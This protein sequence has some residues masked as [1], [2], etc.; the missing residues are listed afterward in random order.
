M[1]KICLEV[2]HSCP[3]GCDSP[4]MKLPEVSILSLQ[5]SVV[6]FPHI[7]AITNPLDD[8]Y[9]ILERF[10][11]IVCWSYLGIA[12]KISAQVRHVH[13]FQLKWCLWR[14]TLM[15]F[16]T[17][18]WYREWVADVQVEIII[19]S[20]DVDSLT[21]CMCKFQAAVCLSILFCSCYERYALQKK[22]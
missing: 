19:I 20:A 4:K 3:N 6:F 22:H 11:M 12:K 13:Y 9:L 5:S 2:L 16:S 14:E 15:L 17:C 8:C 1:D 21:L 10:S 7:C 18:I